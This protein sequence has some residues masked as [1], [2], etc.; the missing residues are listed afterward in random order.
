LK[1]SGIYGP[2][3]EAVHIVINIDRANL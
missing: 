2:M 1:T 3:R